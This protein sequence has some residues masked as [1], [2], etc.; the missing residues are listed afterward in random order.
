M[1][2][3]RCKAGLVLCNWPPETHTHN[4]TGLQFSRN[5]P[6]HT[7]GSPCTHGLWQE[8][9]GEE[10]RKGMYVRRG[11]ARL[12]WKPRG[13]KD[14]RTNLCE[15]EGC[16]RGLNHLRGTDFTGHDDEAEYR[17]NPA[18]CL[19]VLYIWARIAPEDGSYARMLVAIHDTLDAAVR[20]NERLR[21]AIR[22]AMDYFDDRADIHAEN[23]HAPNEEMRL[24]EELN[25]ALS[26]QPKEPE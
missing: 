9:S 26:Q 13:D 7:D 15:D 25:H 24:W 8:R 23:E 14:R 10:R 18:K 1:T 19:D 3:Q 16:P 6:H 21:E 2:E 4:M 17:S 20:E 11:D 5:T 12:G 22:T